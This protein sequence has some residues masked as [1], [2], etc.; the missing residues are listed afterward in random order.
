MELWGSRGSCGTKGATDLRTL[1]CLCAKAQLHGA[2]GIVF[3]AWQFPPEEHDTKWSRQG[4]SEAK[5][6]EGQQIRE[7]GTS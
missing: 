5:F 4:Q 1:N 2:R 3:E 7:Q 6:N